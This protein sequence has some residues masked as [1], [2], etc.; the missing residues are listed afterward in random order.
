LNELGVSRSDLPQI[1]HGQLIRISET[2]TATMHGWLY[3]GKAL[4]E[5]ALEKLRRH[6]GAYAKGSGQ[7]HIAEQQPTG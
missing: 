2:D 7:T 1:T 4:P 5:I 3:L 6:F